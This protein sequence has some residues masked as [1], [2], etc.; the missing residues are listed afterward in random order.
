MEMSIHRALAELKLLENRIS[1]ASSETFVSTNVGNQGPKGFKTVEEFNESAKSSL[2]SVKSLIARRNA[3]KS[4][5]VESNANQ[6]VKIANVEYKVAAAI[7][8][9]S[10]IIFDENL[11]NNMKRQYKVAMDLFERE[12][13][14]FEAKLQQHLV[15]MFGTKDTKNQT[16]DMAAATA[17]FTKRNK[18]EFIDPISL[19]AEIKALEKNIEEFKMEVDFVLSESN[20][21][22]QIEI[23][24]TN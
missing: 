15:S 12:Q 9:K 13:A 3:I 24:D 2:K 8:R 22:T 10:S 19:S 18:V 14:S 23:P 21:S 1:R 16:E 11:L 4:A 17:A 5:I 20:S 6:D 7:D